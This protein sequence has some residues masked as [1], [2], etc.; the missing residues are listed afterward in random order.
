[1]RTPLYPQ[2]RRNACIN[3]CYPAHPTSLTFFLKSNPLVLHKMLK[4][5]R[6]KLR[7]DLK[8]TKKKKKR[9][10]THTFF[11][12][13]CHWSHQNQ[14]VNNN[15]LKI[16]TK[17]FA[18]KHNKKKYFCECFVSCVFKQTKQNRVNI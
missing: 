8:F 18:L 4:R 12:P 11:S 5:L 13:Q 6:V 7:S 9:R 2:H 15:K 3:F 1:M 17:H 16:K 14:V 10:K